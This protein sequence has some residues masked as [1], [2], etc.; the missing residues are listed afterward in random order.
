MVWLGGRGSQLLNR[1]LD[2]LICGDLTI[3][4]FHGCLPNLTLLRGLKD[5]Q[6]ADLAF[7]DRLDFTRG[8]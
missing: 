5:G 3:C 1:I 8:I 7:V 4:G 2:V 6:G